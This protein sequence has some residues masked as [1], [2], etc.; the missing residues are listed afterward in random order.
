MAS[1]LV[2][3]SLKRGKGSR[4]TVSYNERACES[5]CVAVTARHWISSDFP[6]FPQWA[7]AEE[8]TVGEGGGEAAQWLTQPAGIHPAFTISHYRALE[9]LVYN[10]LPKATQAFSLISSSPLQ[11]CHSDANEAC[12]KRNSPVEY[13][14]FDPFTHRR[15]LQIRKN[16]S[17]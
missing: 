14:Q 16:I 15:K 11:I 13:C 7:L 4:D 17:I 8:C 6:L 9:Y 2:R 3:R 12:L 1:F 10:R 5:T